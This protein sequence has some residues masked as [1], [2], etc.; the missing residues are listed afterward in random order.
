MS[1]KCFIK[2]VTF[3]PMI[4]LWCFLFA[5]FLCTNAYSNNVAFQATAEVNFVTPITITSNINIDFGLVS[6]AITDSQTVIV[7]TTGTQTSPPSVGYGSQT[8]S[9]AASLTIT[10]TAS[11]AATIVVDGFTPGAGYVLSDP[12][13]NYDTE[14]EAACT[15][16]VIASTKASAILLIGMTLTGDN[17]ATPADGE[18]PGT[19]D[20]TITYN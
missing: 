5:T 9:R 3:R 15:S 14:G 18:V 1:I 12:T 4:K 19:Y 16:L 7:A 11:H 17:S 20:I 2:H 10:A 13:C 6:S 8:H